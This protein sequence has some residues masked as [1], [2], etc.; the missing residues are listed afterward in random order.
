[1]RICLHQHIFGDLGRYPVSQCFGNVAHEF[2]L[3]YLVALFLF[4]DFRSSNT[5]LP[6]SSQKSVFLLLLFFKLL[7]RIL[8]FE[9]KSFKNCVVPPLWVR[10]L[11]PNEKSKFSK[12]TNNCVRDRCTS[13]QISLFVCF[14]LSTGKMEKQNNPICYHNLLGVMGRSP[15]P[16]SVVVSFYPGSIRPQKKPAHSNQTCRR[17]H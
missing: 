9:E 14:S 16:G 7:V 17:P 15:F 6:S 2:W 5:V 13:R 12:Y 3:C 8:L 10:N 11:I 4:E 1:M